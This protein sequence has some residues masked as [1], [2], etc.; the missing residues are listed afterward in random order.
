MPFLNMV[1]DKFNRKEMTKLIV[2][3]LLM[4]S[5]A[6]TVFYSEYCGTNG[7]YS[8][9]WL[10]SLY[11]IGG[12]IKKYE[13]Y[14]PKINYLFGYVICILITW[15]S[16]II[17]GV[18]TYRAYHEKRMDD[19]L[20]KYTSPTI[21][22]GAIFLLLFFANYKCGKQLKKFIS[23]FAP[24]SFGVYLIHEEPLIRERFISG[25]FVKYLSL[26]NVFMIM[27]IVGTVMIIWLIGSL[28]DKIRLVL[29]DVFKVKEKCIWVEKKIMSVININ[30][31]ENCRIGR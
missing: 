30:N 18:I 22:F 14:L 5:V 8:F 20:I 21:V 31:D 28:V 24:V 17:I 6:Q 3:I 29:F 25:R 9:L 26:N 4:F 13:E 27:A 7:G 1:L 19:Y 16:K 2:C 23:F 10:G 12:Y 11:L 15:S